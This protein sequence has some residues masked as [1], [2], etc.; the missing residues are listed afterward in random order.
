MCQ[1]LNIWHI[2]HT[3]H[4]NDALWDVS[5]LK[6]Y[7]TWLQYRCKFATVRT[8]VVK[9]YYFIFSFLS[10]LSSFFLFSS[11]SLSDSLSLL[12]VPVPSLFDQFEMFTGSDDGIASTT[13]A[14]S[15]TLDQPCSISPTFDLTHAQPR[16]ISPRGRHQSHL[17]PSPLCPPFTL[18]L[19]G[20]GFFFFF[21]FFCCNLGCGL[22]WQVMVQ[23]I[24][25]VVDCGLWAVTVAV[26][27]GCGGDG[28]WWLLVLLMI[29]G[30]G[31]I[32]YFNV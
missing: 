23:L 25:V 21:F 27:V 6:N 22:W 28:R 12:P 29:M 32:Y 5:N 4:K 19:S 13:T 31:I 3:K 9:I 2:C 17:L 1:M 11:L 30:E 26:V 10:P 7:T 8:N 16:S 24:W 20:C 15:A 14:R 18:P